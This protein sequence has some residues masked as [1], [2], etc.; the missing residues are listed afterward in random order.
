MSILLLFLTPI[1]MFFNKFRL[2]SLLRNIFQS[3]LGLK[4]L[5]GYTGSIEAYQNLPELS[6][7]VIELPM[8]D[9]EERQLKN[10]YYARD[11]T[12]WTDIEVLI[13]N[14]NKLS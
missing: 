5:V 6:P 8:D 10:M 3:M 11:Y 7:C 14:L 13:K 2:L 9:R 12:V 1:L 4:T